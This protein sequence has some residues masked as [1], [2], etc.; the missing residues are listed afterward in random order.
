MEN[1]GRFSE[2]TLKLSIKHFYGLHYLVQYPV[3]IYKNNRILWKTIPFPPWKHFQKWELFGSPGHSHWFLNL[4]MIHFELLEKIPGLFL[5]I[6]GR[7]SLSFKVSK[8]TGYRLIIILPK[9]W[10]DMNG[11]EV[12][13]EE[14][15]L[16]DQDRHCVLQIHNPLDLA[17]PEVCP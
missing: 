3:L 11:N 15:K 4:R 2:Q 17:V 6:S 7:S 5:M 10:K 9:H 14:R 16:R 13:T 8:L 12:N 1:A